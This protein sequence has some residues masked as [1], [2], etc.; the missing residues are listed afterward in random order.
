MSSLLH[1]EGFSKLIYAVIFNF[2]IKSKKPVSVPYRVIRKITG[3]TDPTISECIKRL[4][5]GGLIK[6]DPKPGQ[7]TLYTIVLSEEIWAAYLHDSGKQKTA[8]ASEELKVAKNTSSISELTSKMEQGQKLRKYNLRKG[9]TPSNLF[10]S[11]ASSVS[12]R[13]TTIKIPHSS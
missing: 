2:W 7:R 8:K 1:L 9:S 13:V 10:V 3:A 4:V 6:S 5:N 11:S 12:D